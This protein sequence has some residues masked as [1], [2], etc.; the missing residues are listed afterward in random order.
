MVF[1][2]RA[3]IGKSKPYCPSFEA[4]PKR[5]SLGPVGDRNDVGT[6]RQALPGGYVA[7]LDDHV[8]ADDGDSELFHTR[9]FGGLIGF[10][11]GNPVRSRK[12][13]AGH[14]RGFDGER[15]NA[16]TPSAE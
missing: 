1:A 13:Y 8:A 12:R 16:P 4:T 7:F 5:G 6:N 10:A 15:V 14:R 11:S 3:I 2:V 9:S